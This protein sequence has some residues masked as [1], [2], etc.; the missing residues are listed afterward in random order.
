[1]AKIPAGPYAHR[2]E[3]PLFNGRYTVLPTF[4]ARLTPV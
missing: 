2:A 1:M 4:D 3:K